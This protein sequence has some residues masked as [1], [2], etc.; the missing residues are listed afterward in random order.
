MIFDSSFLMAVVEE[1]TT[2]YEDIVEKVG[3]FEPV[4]L[5]CVR[6]ELE[7]MAAGQGR[8]ARAARVSLDMAAGFSRIPCGKARVDDEIAS[9]ALAAKGIV[10]TTDADLAG[11]L[12]A[13]HVKVVTLRA[14]RVALS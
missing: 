5:E 6:S 11:S 9:A 2:W 14:G 12:R 13:V 3:G 1:P 10:A 8:R 4:L 7:K